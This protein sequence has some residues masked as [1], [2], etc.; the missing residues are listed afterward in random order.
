MLLDI[1]QIP[2]SKRARVLGA[3][4]ANN[5]NDETDENDDL[6]YTNVEWVN[7]QVWRVLKNWYTKGETILAEQAASPLTD[8]RNA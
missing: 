6:V 1:T 3:L 4:H 8:I 7:E 5:P 2:V